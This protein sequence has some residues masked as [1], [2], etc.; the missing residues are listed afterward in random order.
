MRKAALPQEIITQRILTASLGVKMNFQPLYSLIFASAV[1][2]ALVTAPAA[3]A[4][5]FRFGYAGEIQTGTVVEAGVYRVTVGG[6]RGG[7]G[8]ITAGGVGALIAGELFLDAGA[9]FDVL[10]GGAGKS[11][12]G[13]GGGGLSYFS[14]GPDALAIAGGG[15]GGAGFGC[16][17]PFNWDRIAFYDGGDGRAATAGQNAGGLFEGKGGSG[18]VD[19]AGGGDGQAYLL[20]NPSADTVEDRW[21]TV[22]GGGGGAGWDGPDKEDVTI[23]SGFSRPEWTGGGQSTFGGDQAGGFGGGGGAGGFLGGGG[24]AGYGGGGGGG[25]GLLD[26]VDEDVLYSFGGG[27]GGS[28]LSPLFTNTRMVTGGASD[29]ALVSVELLESELGSGPT[30]PPVPVPLP[31]ALGLLVAALAVLFGFTR[32]RR[33]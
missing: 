12:H 5:T 11:Y 7:D 33:A 22:E 27:G 32:L 15:G 19:G 3:Q 28:F 1:F 14:A 9:S 16:L 4:A 10:V 25:G 13:G 26:T 24:G 20:A 8:A 18:G 29:G 6:A 23:N 31:G 2:A 21:I 17:C 30:A